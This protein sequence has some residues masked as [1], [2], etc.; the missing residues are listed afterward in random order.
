MRLCKWDNFQDCLNEL[1]DK[2]DNEEKVSNPFPVLSLI[3]DPDIQRKP[4]EI[5]VN[6]KFP[7]GNTLPVINSYQGHEKI[8]IGYF[9]A[10]FRDHPVSYLI[11]ELF[12]IHDRDQF[13]I[14]AFSFGSDTK[15]EMNIRI[16][17][18]IDHFYD[19]RA[20]SDKDIVVL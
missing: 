8:R 19:V 17:K 3:D 18:G 6:Q 4:S 16:K 7:Q 12:E 14:Y 10:E 13:E 11:A 2:I 1:T 20:M 9:S 5:Y 15:D